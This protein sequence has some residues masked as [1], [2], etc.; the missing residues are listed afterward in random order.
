M[1]IAINPWTGESSQSSVALFL[2]KVPS[3]AI[4]FSRISTIG[5][6]VNELSPGTNFMQKTNKQKTFFLTI[7]FYMFIPYSQKMV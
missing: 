7:A 5:P 6:R 1:D 2:E 3:H 4:W